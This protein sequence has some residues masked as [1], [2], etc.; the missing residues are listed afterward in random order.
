MDKFLECD[1]C[2][3]MVKKQCRKN[4]PTHDR[5]GYAVWP[6]LKY[7]DNGC[8]SGVRKEPKKLSD[9]IL[10]ANEEQKIKDVESITNG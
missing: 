2:Q 4:P 9:L 10:E 5:H 7:H 8:F 6:E 1:E 3:C